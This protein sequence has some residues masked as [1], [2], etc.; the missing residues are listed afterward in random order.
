[1]YEDNETKIDWKNIIKKV[2]I[3]IVAI[4]I[5]LGIVSLV[6]KCSHKTDEPDTPTKVDLTKQL[7][8]LERATL[9]YLTKDN[10]PTTINS[11]KTI[12]LKILT[13]KNII[14]GITDDNGNKCDTNS[15]Y[16]EVTRLDNNY[17]VKISLTCGPNSDYRIIYV[18]CFENCNGSICK[19]NEDSTNGICEITTTDN[20]QNKDNTTTKPNNTGN[21]SN[22]TSTN[23]PSTKPNNN[24]NNN[25]NSNNNN[26]NNNNNNSNNNSN[27]PS[28]L[29]NVT[30]YEYKKCS[31]G[32][33]KCTQGSYINGTCERLTAYTEYGKVVTSGGGTTTE[34][35]GNA[36]PKTSSTGS[37][38]KTIN[39]KN[40]G[41]VSTTKPATIKNT[42]TVGYLFKTYSNGKY[43]YTKYTCSQGTIKNSGGKYVCQVTT[44]GTSNTTYSC[45][46]GNVRKINGVYKCVRTVDVPTTSH[47]ELAS[48]TYNKANNTCTKVSYKT[49]YFDPVPG[50][51][52]CETMWSRSTSVSGWTRTGNTKTIRE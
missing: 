34:V 21:S 43:T 39:A 20:S 18:G 28:G 19:G 40:A 4:V 41:T 3:V 14:T 36:T 15:S 8:E 52:T 25:S 7:D 6:K 16:S 2:V 35:L 13:S 26:N 50:S 23:K 17:A 42:S 45:S 29:K 51:S 22:S 30:L 27:K 31:N 1:M 10:L 44:A 33:P 12:R 32:T 11:S 37:S 49:D 24:S 48:F 5:I 46:V 9:T 47:C 38:S